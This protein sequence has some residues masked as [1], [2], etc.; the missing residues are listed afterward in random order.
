M[1]RTFLDGGIDLSSEEG[2]WLP[3][4]GALRLQV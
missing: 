1:L 2:R 3:L 4:A